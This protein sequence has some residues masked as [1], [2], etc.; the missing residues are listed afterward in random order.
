MPVN[1]KLCYVR[2]LP[3]FWSL[4]NWTSTFA[5]KLPLVLWTFC[6]TLR[7]AAHLRRKSS[8]TFMSGH[9]MLFLNQLYNLMSDVPGCNR[10]CAKVGSEYL[11]V[12]FIITLLPG[13]SVK[14]LQWCVC[15]YV[16]VCSHI[17]KVTIWALPNFCCTLPE[18][19]AQ[20]FSSRQCCD[21][22]CTSSFVD[23]FICT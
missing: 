14:V 20:F 9:V 3:E 7:T 13:R 19:M 8:W 11:T 21:E 15:L 10:M 17:W 12:F 23:G 4:V 2:S 1:L 16:C 18:V 5:C 22:L 6:S